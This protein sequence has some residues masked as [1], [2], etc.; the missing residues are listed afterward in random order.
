MENWGSRDGVDWYY[1]LKEL[2][3]QRCAIVPLNNYKKLRMVEA[4]HSQQQLG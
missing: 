1:K 4:D 2:Y 3:L